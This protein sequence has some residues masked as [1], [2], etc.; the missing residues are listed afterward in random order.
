[1]HCVW[2]VEIGAVVFLAWA[3][4]DSFAQRWFLLVSGV[5]S[6]WSLTLHVVGTTLQEVVWAR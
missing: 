6:G 3:S 5:L 2:Y 4:V 1:M